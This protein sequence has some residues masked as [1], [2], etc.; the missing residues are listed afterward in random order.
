[1]QQKKA[2]LGKASQSILLFQIHLLYKK[3]KTVQKEQKNLYL[4]SYLNTNSK[5][6]YLL[7]ETLKMKFV[8][9]YH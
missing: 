8:A 5:V 1:M 2:T 4:S 6:D 3:K 9:R 7:S